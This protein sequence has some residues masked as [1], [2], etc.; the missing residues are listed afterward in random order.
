[1]TAAPVAAVES[2]SPL[3]QGRKLRRA[4][5]F[6]SLSLERAFL[7]QTPAELDIT[8]LGGLASR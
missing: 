1:M 6:I 2:K 4:D 3:R 8:A 5:A 7:E